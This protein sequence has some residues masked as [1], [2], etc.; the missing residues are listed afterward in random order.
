MGIA[1][2]PRRVDLVL[3]AREEEAQGAPIGGWEGQAGEWE[4]GGDLEVG[5]EVLFLVD[6][7]GQVYSTKNSANRQFYS[8]CGHGHPKSAVYCIFQSL[9]EQA[10]R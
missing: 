10:G 4:K 9:F 1:T 3:H 5:L 7:L 2:G 6:V 8:T